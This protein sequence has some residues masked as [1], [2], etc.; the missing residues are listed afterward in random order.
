LCMH[1]SPCLLLL[2]SLFPSFTC[3]YIF[4]TIFLINILSSFVSSAVIV[5][6]SQP[7]VGM[8]GNKIVCTLNLIY[9]ERSSDVRR[10]ICARY[11][12]FAVTVLTHNAWS[13][14]KLSFP[15]V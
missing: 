9:E 14:R 2:F 12:R 7:Q 15:L 8:G 11:A 13:Q 3:P 6:V 10:L 1:L 4:L 5:R